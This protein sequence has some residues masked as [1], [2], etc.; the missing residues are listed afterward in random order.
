M[1]DPNEIS[2]LLDAFDGALPRIVA[3]VRR[4]QARVK[5]LEELFSLQRSRMDEAVGFWRGQ[6]G[7][8]KDTP[9]LGDLLAFLLKEIEERGKVI[10]RQQRCMPDVRDG[11]VAGCSGPAP[12]H[13]GPPVRA[14]AVG[15]PT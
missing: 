3:G 9:S 14:T 12:A 6:T 11:L 4:Q 15:E 7:R 13:M 5:E 1:A 10:E 8:F 2:D